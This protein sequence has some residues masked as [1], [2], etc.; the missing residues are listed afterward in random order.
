MTTRQFQRGETVPIW[1]EIK[2]WLGAYFDPASDIKLTITNPLNV[3]KVTAVAM[4]RSDTGKYTYDYQSIA[5]DEA[6][7][8]KVKALA[9]DGTSITIEYGGFNL[10]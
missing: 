4:T 10:Q 8:W 6:G 9:Q 3:D 2:T 5:G 7:W 1:V